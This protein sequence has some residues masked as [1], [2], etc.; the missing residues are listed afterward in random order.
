MAK[1]KK[2]RKKTAQPKKKVKEEE[3]NQVGQ[4]FR[5]V[6]MNKHGDE[7]TKAGD[8]YINIKQK[9]QN[10]EK[11]ELA[12]YIVD[13]Y[14]YDLYSVAVDA[15]STLRQIIEEMMLKRNFLSILTNNMTAFRQNSTQRVTE[16]ANEFILT[17]GKYVAL[18]DALLGNETMTS[19]QLFNP[20]VV[21]IGVSGIIAKKGF[22]CHGNDEVNV[23]KLLFN[24]DAAKIVIP[25]DH[26]KLGKSD[27]YIFG[28]TS[29]FKNRNDT[30]CIVVTMAPPYNDA[31]MLTRKAN[32][33]EKQK[34]VYEQ[35]K[36]EL[37]EVGIEVHEV[38]YDL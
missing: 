36:K 21:L 11:K 31:D 14:I 4:V 37:M 6:I 19:F 12:K 22:F 15:G 1:G 26:S 38:R 20:N 27:S 24:K 33:L 18:F 9:M 25:V 34:E 23:K 10:E 30:E 8:A 16:S 13:N 28:E 2:Q 17:G 35:Q 7:S 32:V 3:H 5:E 29:G